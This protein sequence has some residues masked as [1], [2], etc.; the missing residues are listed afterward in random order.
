MAVLI[1]VTIPEKRRTMFKMGRIDLIFLSEMWHIRRISG[2]GG[3]L[4]EV[5]ELK[6][7]N[8]DQDE[9]SKCSQNP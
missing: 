3:G 5:S 9:S 1:P 6:E 4:R 8:L 2:A 7:K